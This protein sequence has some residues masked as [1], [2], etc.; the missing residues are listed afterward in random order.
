MLG[1]PAMVTL[2]PEPDS[3]SSRIPFTLCRALWITLPATEKQPPVLFPL[4]LFF[5][6]SWKQVLPQPLDEP[7]EPRHLAATAGLWHLRRTPTRENEG[8]KKRSKHR[9]IHFSLP[10]GLRLQVL[11]QQWILFRMLGKCIPTIFLCAEEKAQWCSRWPGRSIKHITHWCNILSK[12]TFLNPIW[13]YV[14]KFSFVTCF[15]WELG[16]VA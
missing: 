15:S 10:D 14:G 5:Q 4:H 8:I 1:L 3:K 13:H 11:I 12:G 6:L 2:L 9:A 7:A 16:K